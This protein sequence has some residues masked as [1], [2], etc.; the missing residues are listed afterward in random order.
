LEFSVFRPPQTQISRP[1]SCWPIHPGMADYQAPIMVQVNILFFGTWRSMSVA[2]LASSKQ[3]VSWPR[4]LATALKS[5]CWLRAS[6][7]PATALLYPCWLRV[8]LELIRLVSIY[9]YIIHP[10][11]ADKSEGGCGPP[12]K[13]SKTAEPTCSQQMPTTISILSLPLIVLRNG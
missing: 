1:M 10:A 12:S 7:D 2:V 5:P 9:M 11:H 3:N 6:Y 13:D 4:S 8:S